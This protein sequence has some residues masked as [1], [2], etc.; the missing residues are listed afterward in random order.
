MSR[1]LADD[2]LNIAHRHLSG[3]KIYFMLFS[4]PSE[5]HKAGDGIAENE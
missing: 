1:L 2:S 3:I 5:A 4:R